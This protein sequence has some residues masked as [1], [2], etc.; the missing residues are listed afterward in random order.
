MLKLLEKMVWSDLK[1]VKELYG[2]S[3]LLFG[4]QVQIEKM[5]QKILLLSLDED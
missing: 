2:N 3:S 4:I 1:L 5:L